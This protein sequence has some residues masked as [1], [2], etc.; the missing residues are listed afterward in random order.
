[1]RIS[2]GYPRYPQVAGLEIGLCGY[3]PDI[4]EGGGGIQ[5][6]KGK[7]IS[8]GLISRKKCIFFY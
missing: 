5:F 1:M 2:D 3:P 8:R 4:R 6:F 7:F